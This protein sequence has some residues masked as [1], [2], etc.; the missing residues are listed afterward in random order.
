MFKASFHLMIRRTLLKELIIERVRRDL[1]ENSFE[2][3]G[4]ILTLVLEVSHV[5]RL[6][7]SV[8]LYFYF[9]LELFWR[10]LFVSVLPWSIRF[11]IVFVVI[12]NDLFEILSRLALYS[13]LIILD[14]FVLPCIRDL[15]FLRSPSRPL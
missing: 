9:S 11:S 6:C 10:T 15:Y 12:S 14:I 1:N 2:S 7:F 4:R 5:E 13:I 3:K 8:L